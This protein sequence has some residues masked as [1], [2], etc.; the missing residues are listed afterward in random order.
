MQL[1]DLKKFFSKSE[2]KK[3]NENKR[4]KSKAKQRKG[5]ERKRIRD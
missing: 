3:K 2:N 1:Y 5:D 4:L